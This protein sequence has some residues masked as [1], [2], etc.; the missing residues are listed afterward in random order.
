LFQRIPA[1]AES[2]SVSEIGRNVVGLPILGG[3]HHDYQRAA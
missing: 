2:R 3:L 1:L